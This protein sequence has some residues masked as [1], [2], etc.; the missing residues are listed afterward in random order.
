[1]LNNNFVYNW[2]NSSYGLL[3]KEIY[4]AEIKENTFDQNTIGIFVEGSNRIIYQ[5]NEFI[6]N[7]WAI[8]FSGG[9]EDN[10]ITHNNFLYNTLDMLVSTR[11]ADN[12]VSNNYWSEYSG[13]DLDKDGYGD[14]PH[15]P[16]TL[17]SYVLDMVPE[18]VVLMRSL[19]VDLINYAEKV[20]PVFTPKDVFDQLPKMTAYK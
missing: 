5:Y 14:V 18:S 7:G 15:Y 20:S 19:F 1:M 10:E 8:K 2:G 9:C 3:L 11:L 4:D 16:V 12:V 13:Y 17:Y 6:R